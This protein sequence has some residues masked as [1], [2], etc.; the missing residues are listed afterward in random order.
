[1]AV[2]QLIEVENSIAQ[3]IAFTNAK[4]NEQF[5]DKM[6]LVDHTKPVETRQNG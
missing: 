5:R 6:H 2:R 3:C 1:M 4:V